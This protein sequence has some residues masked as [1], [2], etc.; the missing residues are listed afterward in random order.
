MLESGSSGSVRG[1][2]SNGRPYREPF[3]LC[4]SCAGAHSSGASLRLQ[5]EPT[6]GCRIVDFQSDLAQAVPN[7]PLASAA[8]AVRSLG[9]AFDEFRLPEFLL[10]KAQP[11]SI[12][13][14]RRAQE[15]ADPG[16]IFPGLR[17]RL[18][19]GGPQS[20]RRCLSHPRLR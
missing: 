12:R 9:Y 5:R 8:G 2:S 13:A 15:R 1:A 20:S 19:R 6:H 4:W 14:R 7:V 17:Q 11:A 18:R 10:E 3:R 16:R